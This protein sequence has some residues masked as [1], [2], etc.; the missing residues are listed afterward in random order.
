MGIEIPRYECKHVARQ[1]CNAKDVIRCDTAQSELC[2][3][4]PVYETRKEVLKVEAH[5]CETLKKDVCVN[6]DRLLCENVSKENC[7]AVTHR[8]CLKKP[9]MITKMECTQVDITTCIDTPVT[10]VETEDVE[11]CFAVPSSS[12]QSENLKACT[13]VD[14]QTFKD[15]GV[16][17]CKE[18]EKEVCYPPEI[19]KAYR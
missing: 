19:D 4:V 2:I 14:L 17:N 18:V 16:Q 15:V 9:K 11:V 5:I 12:C 6:V 8:E 10:N 3:D 7:V 13:S 1:E